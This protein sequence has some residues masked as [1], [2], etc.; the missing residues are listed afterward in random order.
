MTPAESVASKTVDRRCPG[1]SGAPVA[2]KFLLL[3]DQQEYSGD[4]V[5]EECF[6][7]CE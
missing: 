1:P 3:L 4:T 2:S 5:G 7:I 6:R